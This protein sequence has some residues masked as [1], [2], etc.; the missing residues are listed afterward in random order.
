MRIDSC[1][2]LRRFAAGPAL[3]STYPLLRMNEEW[4]RTGGRGICLGLLDT[5]VDERIPD[6]SGAELFI[7][8][9]TASTQCDE[10]CAGHGSHSAG[11]LVGQGHCQIRGIAPRIRLLVA[12]VFDSTGAASPEAVAAAIAWVVSSTAQIVALPLG[13]QTEHRQIAHEIERSVTE[14]GTLFFAAAGNCHPEPVLFP[15]RH[16][17][18]VAVGAADFKGVLLPECSRTPSLD[19]VAPGWNIHGPIRRQV[20]RQRRGSSVACVV[21]AGIA[22]LALSAGATWPHPMCRTSI[23]TALRRSQ[24]GR[25]DATV[26]APSEQ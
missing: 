7:K 6:L 9:F 19:L 4:R 14:K 24:D 15:A 16:P 8:H 25:H 11:L 18:V 12:N 2:M 20:I 5:D 17:L 10:S 3:G 21:A 23:L 26:V 22:A 1:G 13:E